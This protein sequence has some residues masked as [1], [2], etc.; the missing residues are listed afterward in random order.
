MI[1][2]H[3][4]YYLGLCFVALVWGANFGVSRWAMDI[5]PLEIFVFLRFGLALP[6]LL[7][8]LKWTEG[9][10]KVD[11]RDLLMLAFIGLLGITA[12]EIIVLYSIKFTTLANASL[13]NVA[14]WPIFVALLAPLFTREFLTSRV[15]IG[16]VFALIGVVFIIIGG[17]N[18]FDLSSKYM[19]GNMLALIISL[20][21]AVYNLLCM[22]LMK[23]YSALRVTTWFILFGSIFMF[24]A[25]WGGWG[26]VE[27]SS[28]SIMAW[29][30]VAYNVLFCTVAAFV[31][32]NLCM[33]KVG[34]TKANFY[35]YLVPA[36]ATLAGALFFAEPILP[37]QITG[38][39]I[40][41]L[42]LVWISLEKMNE[43]RK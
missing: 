34:A 15:V 17:Q 35:R 27:W 4:I 33:H 25:T 21:G 38:G 43:M 23:K 13:L 32:W 14:P 29:S 24:P 1:K 5:F 41:V 8:I 3:R 12:L 18:G 7:L 9:S 10:V 36:A 39:V 37:L 26:K 11:R 28:L 40:I 6:I 16:G 22:P 31:I 42:G 20:F 2:T 30:A 19:L